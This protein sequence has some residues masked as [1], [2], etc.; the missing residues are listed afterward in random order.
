MK[1]S[2]LVL[3]KNEEEM[4]GECLAQL[5]FA[6]EII[7]LDQNS[8]DS[9]SQVAKKYA[10][11]VVTSKID[12]FSENRN[13]LSGLARGQWLFYLDADERLKNEA[14]KEIKWAIGANEHNAYYFP[15]KNIILGKWLR[16]GGW[17]P[18]YVPRLF[19]K[20]KLLGW[21]GRI[22]E[23]P[24]IEGDFGYFKNPI[25]HLTARNFSQMFA[26]TVKWAKIEAE[27]YQAAQAK[28]VT[29]FQVIKV[30]VGEFFRR[31]LV[32][33][34]FLDGI[35]GLIESIFQA[36]HQAIVLTYL[37]ELQHN[38]SKKLKSPFDD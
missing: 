24:R 32:K 22:H 21:Q 13:M 25:E 7:V 31:Y 15:R 35:V 29:G 11:K 9:T 6:D 26:K 27:L 4:I 8:A 3:A 1:I 17:W 19:K 34:G 28:D 10:T 23:S 33:F 36:L 12:D 30:M 20:D 14:L 18:D 16:H 38:S 2:A 37:W 5:K